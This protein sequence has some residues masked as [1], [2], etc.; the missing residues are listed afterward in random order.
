MLSSVS[1]LIMGTCLVLFLG[2]IAT[3]ALLFGKQGRK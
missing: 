1:P 3:C 2:L